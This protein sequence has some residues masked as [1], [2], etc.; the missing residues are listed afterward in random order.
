[1][2]IPHLFEITDLRIAL[3]EIFP[4]SNYGTIPLDDQIDAVEAYLAVDENELLDAPQALAAY[5]SYQQHNIT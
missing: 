5:V 2:T 1:M 3:S 4:E